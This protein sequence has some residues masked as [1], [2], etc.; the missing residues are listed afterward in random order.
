MVPVRSL[1][2]SSVG[3]LATGLAVSLVYQAAI[4]DSQTVAGTPSRRDTGGPVSFTATAYCKGATTASGAPVR[5]G[6]VAADPRTLPLG[7]IVEV[8]GVPDGYQGVYTVLDTGPKVQ[9]RHL[10]LYMWSCHEALA[11][12]RRPAT[13]T[14]LRRGWS[15]SGD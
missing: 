15:P 2:R 1:M 13:V 6:V 14:V 12:G 9:G 5:A 7:S 4:V 10:D 8:N 3:L 11:F